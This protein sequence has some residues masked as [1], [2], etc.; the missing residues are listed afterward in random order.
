MHEHSRKS[1]RSVINA[2][3]FMEEWGPEPGESVLDLGCGDGFLSIAAARRTGPGGI[4]Y[5]LDID[6]DWVKESEAAAADLTNIRWVSGD[7][8]REIPVERNRVDY[9]LMASVLHGFV[10]NDELAPVMR[11]VSRVLKPGGRLVVVEFKKA[12]TPFGPPV[13]IRLGPA[14]V[15]SVLGPFGYI[16]EHSNMCAVYHHQTTLQHVPSGDS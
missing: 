11:E 9:V 7:A 10:A 5:A 8:T 16:L 4:V 15:A 2:P 1:S 12:S 3:F 13:E 6:R 14:D